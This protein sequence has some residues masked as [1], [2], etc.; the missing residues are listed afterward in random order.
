MHRTFQ[1]GDQTMCPDYKRCEKPERLEGTPEECTPEQIRKC[2]GDVDEHP[3]TQKP[4]E[5]E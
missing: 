2:H 1:Q 5:S 4:G 3:C